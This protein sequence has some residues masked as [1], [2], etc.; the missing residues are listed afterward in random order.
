MPWPIAAGLM[1]FFANEWGL[2]QL[3]LVDWV[4]Y[5][6]CALVAALG[7]SVLALGVKTLGVRVALAVDVCPL[8]CMARCDWRR[9]VLARE[10]IYSYVRNPICLGCVL[11][12]FSVAIGF[13]SVPGLSLAV[14]ALVVA[15]LRIVL[16]EE[17][18]LQN[19]FGAEYAEYMSK[20]GRF[21]PRLTSISRKQVDR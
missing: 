17:K 15:Y 19:Q 21:I 13:K 5:L 10:G 2:P 14:L 8:R 7:V 4:A 11:L 9:S 1:S 6:A 18:G 12:A 16:Y 20:V 3:A